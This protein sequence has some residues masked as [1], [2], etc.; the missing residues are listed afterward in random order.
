MLYW[1]TVNHVYLR[2]KRGYSEAKMPT[3]QLTDISIR[4]LK[5][6]DKGQRL[7]RDKNLKGFCVRVSQGGTKTYVLV[8]GANRQFT[9]IGRVDALKLSEA[10]KEA[11]RL[12]A[13][14]TLGK[15]KLASYTF[16]EVQE[17]FFCACKQKNKPRTVSD[18]KRL[19]NRHFRLSKLP[20]SEIT[21][22]EI[23]RRVNKLKSTPFE[24][25]HAFVTARVFFRWATA[26]D[27]VEHNPLEG[28]SLPAKTASRTYILSDD[29][30]KTVYKGA[31]AY[32]KH[33]GIIVA[34]LILTG[35]RRT[36]IASLQWDW[37][38]KKDRTITL[39]ASITKNKHE[40]TFPYGR[41]VEG[42]LER[43]KTIEGYLFPARRAHVG[44]KPTSH[45][46][47]WGNGKPA[48]GKT[49]DGV[50]PFTL[51][52]LRRTMSSK[53]AELGTPIH[54]TERLLNHIS[55]TVSGVA[56]IYNRHTYLKEMR[57]AVVTYESCIS[58]LSLS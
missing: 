27:Y 16:S 55:G 45:F 53:H 47:G 3:I 1:N 42:Q 5:P 34:L 52:D 11:K 24:Q 38:N 26:H 14:Y 30:L 32:D 25:N 56:A 9:T 6:P 49:I 37:I 4:S 33:Y 51:H 35:Q 54:I 7:Y 43:V 23:M 28:M 57:D 46:N 21:K 39:P 20:M 15:G 2:D 12:L 48:F 17:A 50:S 41:L 22:H 36:E 44:D 19:L 40:H 10:R 18:Y 13:E 8:H 31:L 58:R 29:D